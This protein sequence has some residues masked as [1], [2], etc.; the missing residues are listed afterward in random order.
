M[1]KV[2]IKT[3]IE[4]QEGEG[5]RSGMGFGTVEMLTYVEILKIQRMPEM[6]E[7]TS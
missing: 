4:E 5:K 7:G 2:E 1:K 3:E 6:P